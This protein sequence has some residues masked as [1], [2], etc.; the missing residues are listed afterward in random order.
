MQ[1]IFKKDKIFLM[2]FSKSMI[3]ETYFNKTQ[4]NIIYFI[5]ILESLIL[6]ILINKLF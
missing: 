2:I 6:T 4:V 1:H 3:K 5:F